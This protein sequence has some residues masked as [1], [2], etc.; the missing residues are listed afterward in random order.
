MNNF[1]QNVTLEKKENANYDRFLNYANSF[2]GE[3]E[4][5]ISKEKKDEIVN[6]LV[7]NESEI[8]LQI[9]NK[10]NKEVVYDKYKKTFFVGKESV[11]LGEI[12]SSLNMGEKYYLPETLENS[13]AGKTLR[14]MIKEKY[15]QSFLSEKLNKELALILSK[16]SQ[17]KDLLKS[18]AYKKISERSGEENESEQLGVIAEK[19]MQGVAEMISIDRPD[20]GI[21]VFT[22]NAYQ[23]VEEKIDFIVATKHKVRGANIETGDFEEKTIGIQFTI[24][25]KKESFKNEQ[26]EKSKG[27]VMDIDD[28]VYVAIDGSLL[29]KAIY[30]WESKNKPVSG[31]WAELPKDIKKKTFEALFKSLISDEQEKSLL[32]SF[33]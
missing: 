13:L 2:L 23:D 9:E 28:I 31:P 17:N 29:K 26:I 3:S 6:S 11:S 20:L 32:K 18:R 15:E 4:K 14:K 10:D 16:E 24:N 21:S 19:L 1:E 22:S 27:R 5:Y 7:L 8:N 12:M 30:E 33:D 25:T